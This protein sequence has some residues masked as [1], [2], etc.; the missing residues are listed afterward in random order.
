M[1]GQ[2]AAS[3]VASSGLQWAVPTAAWK[4]AWKAD[5]SVVRMVST[6]V[7]ALAAK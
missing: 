7:H 1:D 3:S 6:M 4:V 2:L 5:Y